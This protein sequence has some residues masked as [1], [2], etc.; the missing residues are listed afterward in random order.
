MLGEGGPVPEA[1]APQADHDRSAGS[2]FVVGREDG[3]AVNFRPDA[4]RID[5]LN[6]ARDGSPRLA[7]VLDDL[8]R[9]R[10]GARDIDLLH[11]VAHDT[12]A[13]I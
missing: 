9:K 7:G 5:Q 11:D 10:A 3:R 1:I 8:E 2:A 6:K 12:A 13:G 4:S